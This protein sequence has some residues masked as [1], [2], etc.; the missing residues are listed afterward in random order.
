MVAGMCVCM[1]V[2]VGWVCLTRPKKNIVMF[3]PGRM[4]TH[5]VGRISIFSLLKPLFMMYM[6]HVSMNEKKSHPGSPAET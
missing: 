2:G 1:C 3:P 6:K 5:P 4:G